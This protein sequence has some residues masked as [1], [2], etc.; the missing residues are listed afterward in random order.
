MSALLDQID[1]LTTES[2]AEAESLANAEDLD[3]YR[4]KYLGRKDGLL[5]K[6][7]AALP[8]LAGDE[9]REVGKRANA[10]KLAIESAIL[11]GSTSGMGMFGG[12]LAVGA[13]ATVFVCAKMDELTSVA[14]MKNTCFMMCLFNA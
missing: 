14:A 8:G 9:K 1:A 11:R 12:I 4:L 10:L 7:L 13:M 6:I 5:T 2:R 3:A